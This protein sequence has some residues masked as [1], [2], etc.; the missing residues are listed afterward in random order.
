MKILCIIMWLGFLGYFEYKAFSAVG[1]TYEA[2][3]GSVHLI[4]QVALLWA[5][6]A[7]LGFLAGRG[8]SN[9]Q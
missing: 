9:N 4:W 8:D 2:T 6:P 3:V 5:F 1:I 7:L